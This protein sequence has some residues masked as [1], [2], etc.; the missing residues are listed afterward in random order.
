MWYIFLRVLIAAVVA[1]V[2]FI[3][4]K[5]RTRKYTASAVATLLREVGR[6]AKGN[7]L[8]AY[9]YCVDG[10]C[11]EGKTEV[12]PGLPLRIGDR[13]EILYDPAD[14]VKSERKGGVWLGDGPEALDESN[15]QWPY[16]EQ[17]LATITQ[18]NASSKL[19]SQILFTYEA[20]G[21]LYEGAEFIGNVF[22]LS[23]GD[24]LEV[25][26]K[27]KSPDEFMTRFGK[28]KASPVK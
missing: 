28:G 12:L 20:C 17:T 10:T 8:L 15:E 18:R 19:R 22:K 5:R 11:Y 3:C 7:V 9:G 4:F 21:E 14:P 13:I 24:K 6:T 25:L 16:T 1:A 27:P 26:Y 23:E 2:A